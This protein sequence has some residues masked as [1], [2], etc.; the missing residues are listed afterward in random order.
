MKNV[1]KAI[2]AAVV[3]FSGALVTAD[4]DGVIDSGEWWWIA[5]TTVSAAAAVWTVRN[6]DKPPVASR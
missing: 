4:A 3:G 1:R 2:V 5:A 6:G